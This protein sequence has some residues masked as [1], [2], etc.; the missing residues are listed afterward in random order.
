MLQCYKFLKT[1]WYLNYEDNYDDGS[2]YFY[3]NN[4]TCYSVI[5]ESIGPY[6]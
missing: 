6:F 4:L 1:I 2:T 3:T 5:T